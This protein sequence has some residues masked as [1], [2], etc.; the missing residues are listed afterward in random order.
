M[1]FYFLNGQKFYKTLYDKSRNLHTDLAKGN[2]LISIDN[3]KYTANAKNWTAFNSINEVIKYVNSFPKAERNFYE[4]RKSKA[5]FKIFFDVDFDL[6]KKEEIFEPPPNLLEEFI[7]TLKFGFSMFF[8]GKELEDKDI[9]IYT[10]CRPTKLSYHIVLPNYHTSDLNIMKALRDFIY[11]DL[12][13]FY[14]SKFC[15][16]LKPSVIDRAPYNDNGHFRLLSC[17]KEKYNNG[18]KMPYGNTPTSFSASLLTKISS[19][20]EELKSYNQD[21]ID[22]IKNLFEEELSKTCEADMEVGES[23]MNFILDNLSLER[24][25]TYEDWIKIGLAIFNTLGEAGE[26]FFDHFSQRSDKYDENSVSKTWSG[27]RNGGC[28]K[29]ISYGSLLFFLKQDNLNAFLSLKKSLNP[30]GSLLNNFK[31]LFILSDPE[32]PNITFTEFEERY[33]EPKRFQQEG[34]ILCQSY[35]NTGKTHCLS[36][37]P[38]LNDITKNVLILTNRIKLAKEFMKRFYA[39]K[40]SLNC[41]LNYDKKKDGIEFFNRVIIQPESLWKLDTKVVYDV[42]ILDECESVFTQFTSS[43]MKTRSIEKDHVRPRIEGQM[44]FDRHAEFTNRWNRITMKANKLVFCD[45]FLSNRTIEMYRTLGRKGTILKNTYRP[46]KRKAIHIPIKKYPPP[47]RGESISPLVDKAAEEL[48]KGKNIFIVVSSLPKMQ[49]FL[50]KFK[51]QAFSKYVGKAYSSK[52][53]A[54]K[55]LEFDCEQEWKV[56]NYVIITTSI[57]TGINFNLE[58]FDS[59][60][61]YFQSTPLVRDL[62][63]SIMRVRQLRENT[64]YYTVSDYVFGDKFTGESNIEEVK[65]IIKSRAEFINENFSAVR[66]NSVESL[67]TIAAYNIFERCCQ[68][69]VFSYKNIIAIFFNMCNYEMLEEGGPAPEKVIPPEVEEDLPEDDLTP[70]YHDIFINVIGQDDFSIRNVQSRLDGETSSKI[71]ILKNPTCTQPDKEA[72]IIELE[73]SLRFDQEVICMYYYMK[74]FNVDKTIDDFEDTWYHVYYSLRRSPAMR[75]QAARNT[76]FLSGKWYDPTIETIMDGT[77]PRVSELCKYYVMHKLCEDLSITYGPNDSEEIARSSVR[78]YSPELLNKWAIHYFKMQDK[79]K[80]KGKLVPVDPK[81]ITKDDNIRY[82][83]HMFESFG[84]GKITT[85]GQSREKRING[86]RI[87]TTP[88]YL[89][90][91]VL[92]NNLFAMQNSHA[93]PTI[94][95]SD[96]LKLFFDTTLNIKKQ[97]YFEGS[98]LPYDP[99]DKKGKNIV[100]DINWN[101]I[102]VEAGINP[103]NDM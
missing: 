90:F 7:R 51:T 33:V 82:I 40:Y 57:T 6:V 66:V 59:V 52:L 60:F 20:S 53:N 68:S 70:Q 1:S 37:L 32:D 88:Y 67:A 47:M 100:Q 43:T 28:A 75:A 55:M 39:E 65:K 96:K 49:M 42:V 12:K 48:K 45:A 74:Q 27:F 69:Y 36:L 44:F 92:L 56:C 54:G 24:A 5:P 80:V 76:Q 102:D 79:K 22:E 89:D 21:L 95:M 73:K 10:S 9:N 19:T 62:F 31:K 86:E 84:G 64:L 15:Y 38:Q 99:N 41:Y 46:P 16:D 63:Q 85:R 29:K 2:Y 72:Q 94:N 98:C 97:E 93:P 71:C 26:I 4:Y 35:L 103:Y 83:N 18:W 17:K 25:D 3:S 78:S 11:E 23:V 101:D 8:Y 77:N 13:N 87:N 58:H 14:Y 50:D 30:L 91:D 81:K 34:D 61:V